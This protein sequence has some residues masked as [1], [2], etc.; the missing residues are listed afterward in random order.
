MDGAR[1]PCVLGETWWCNGGGEKVG[2]G[3]VE[4]S[5]FRG[6][7]MDLGAVVDVDDCAVCVVGPEYDVAAAVQAAAVL[8]E[9]EA[10]DAAPGVLGRTE[11][12]ARKAA[13]KFERKGRFEVIIGREGCVVCRLCYDSLVVLRES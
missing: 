8:V 1:V 3:E 12:W 11:E 6:S 13:R 2:P 4:G 9:A 7:I 10:L 5:V